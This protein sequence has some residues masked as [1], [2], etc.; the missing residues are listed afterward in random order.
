[1]RSLGLRCRTVDDKHHC[2]LNV[3]RDVL[4]ADFAFA[5]VALAHKFL[6]PHLGSCVWTTTEASWGR[7]TMLH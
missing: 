7:F 2:P 4:G 6:L 5:Q 1:L 3:G